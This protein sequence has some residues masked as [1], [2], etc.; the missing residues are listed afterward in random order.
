MQLHQATTPAMDAQGTD[1][2][3]DAAPAGEPPA[4]NSHPTGP[5]VESPC[6]TSTAPT[7]RQNALHERSDL[8]TQA[9]TQA[10]AGYLLYM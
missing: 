4:P 2:E 7:K 3:R 8:M 9:L 1:Q 6:Q 10:L 5:T